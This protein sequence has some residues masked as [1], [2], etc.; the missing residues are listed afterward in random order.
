[1]T[2][3]ELAEAKNYLIGSYALRFTTSTRI[4]RQLL[5]IQLEELGIDYINRRND[6]IAAVT[7]DDIRRVA[8]RLFSEDLTLVRVG[9]PAS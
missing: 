6:L 4:A 2:A 8:R 1:V 9:Q 3:D 7:I 5:A